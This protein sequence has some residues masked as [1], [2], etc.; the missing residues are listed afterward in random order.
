M[1]LLLTESVYLTGADGY[2]LMCFLRGCGFSARKQRLLACACCRRIW[3]LLADA[4]YRQAIEVAERYA[5]G[6][7]RKADLIAARDAARA[8]AAE[9]ATRALAAHEGIPWCRSSLGVRIQQA[10]SW[11]P[12]ALAAGAGGR[13]SRDF[14]ECCDFAAT[15]AAHVPGQPPEER[16]ASIRAARQDLAPLVH[17]VFGNPFRPRAIEP[18]WL[19][20]EDARVPT[21]ARAIDGERRLPEGTLNGDRFAVLA[22]ALEEAGCDDPAILA[23]CRGSEPHVS[24]CW[25]L[26]RLLGKE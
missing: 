6:L 22:G 20:W 3:H 1:A 4:R 14:T 10:S 12:A 24:G 21:L 9:E 25:L 16:E 11:H 15:L 8:A 7:A 23:H 5:E 13:T 26:D 2:I 17:D 19:V 18:G